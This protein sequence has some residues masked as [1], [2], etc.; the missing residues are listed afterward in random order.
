M[1]DYL[2][3]LGN[4]T[5]ESVTRTLGEPTWDWE[6]VPSGLKGET[7]LCGLRGGTVSTAG[8]GDS[9]AACRIFIHEDGLCVRPAWD[10]PEDKL[11]ALRIH[12]QLLKSHS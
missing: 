7:P 9:A 4:F 11:Y 12:A 6:V 10:I 5:R 8:W 2:T 1:M 3:I